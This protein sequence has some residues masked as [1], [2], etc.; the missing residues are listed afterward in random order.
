METQAF[1]RDFR[2]TLVE[3]LRGAIALAREPARSAAFKVLQQAQCPSVLV[4]L[5]YMSNAQDAGLLQSAEWQG[6]VAGSIKSAIDAYFVKRSA[7]V[8]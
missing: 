6:R 5:G 2:E 8:P 3:K 7:K 4:E 1:S